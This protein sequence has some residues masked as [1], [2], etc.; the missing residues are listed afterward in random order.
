M[1][2]WGM[3]GMALLGLSACSSSEETEL[4]LSAETIKVNTRASNG[5]RSV[6]TGSLDSYFSLL[7]WQEA[8]WNKLASGT[9]ATPL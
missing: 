1:I 9:E 3:M 2:Q 4:E 7:F 6:E 8:E 5:S